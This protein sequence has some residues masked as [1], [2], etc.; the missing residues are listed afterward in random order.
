MAVLT[1][2]WAPGQ[3]FCC[4]TAQAAT[5]EMVQVC[6]V[7]PGSM[8]SCCTAERSSVP[9]T[10]PTSGPCDDSRSED[11]CGCLHAPV[12]VAVPMAITLAGHG[13]HGLGDLDLLL[14]LPPALGTTFAGADAGRCCRGS[15][16]GPPANTLLRQSC[17]LLI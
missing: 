9:A 4:C 3:L 1:A 10:P 5:A 7:E 2:T 8:S 16:H 17:L 11:G 6:A 12:D 14:Q 15:P 13:M